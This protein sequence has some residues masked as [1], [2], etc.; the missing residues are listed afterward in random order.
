MHYVFKSPLTASLW[1]GR[2]WSVVCI[3]E[4]TL[5]GDSE[6]PEQNEG[7]DE[8]Q[9]GKPENLE[10]HAATRASIT[11]IESIESVESEDIAN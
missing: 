2:H 6:E 7:T 1:H 10:Q 9:S 3:R 4:Q 5:A 11:S 8:L